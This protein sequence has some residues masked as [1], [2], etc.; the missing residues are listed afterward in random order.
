MM[1]PSGHLRPIIPS[2]LS[3]ILELLLN[4][5]VSLPHSYNSAPVEELAACLADEH[6]I[7]RQVSTQVMS[8]F[9]VVREGK[10]AMDVDAVLKQIG[11]GILRRHK[12]TSLFLRYYIQS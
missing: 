1:V 8:W 11:L 5:L 10:W 7:P 3:T 2:Y 4:Y 6:E 12:V 9:G